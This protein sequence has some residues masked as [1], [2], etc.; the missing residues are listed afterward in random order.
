MIFSAVDADN[1]N[2]MVVSVSKKPLGGDWATGMVQLT[3]RLIPYWQLLCLLPNNQLKV[4]IEWGSEGFTIGPNQTQLPAD[5][6]WKWYGTSGTGTPTPLTG[7]ASSLPFMKYQ[8]RTLVFF[9]TRTTPDYSAWENMI[10][11]DAFYGY[12]AEC[13]LFAGA[14]AGQRMLETGVLTFDVEI[15][16][17]QRSIS[18]N[19]AFN[20]MTGQWE[21]IKRVGDGVKMYSTCAFSGIE[22]W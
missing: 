20:D 12:P 10:S 1:P 3:A 8:L 7:Q 14:S 19:K 2:L 15:R 16:I 11:S 21:Y 5:Q 6:A 22:D 17:T 9:G 4:R 13:S 18:F